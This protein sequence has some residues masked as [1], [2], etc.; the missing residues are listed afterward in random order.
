MIAAMINDKELDPAVTELLVR[1]RKLNIF[2]VFIIKPYFK[3]QK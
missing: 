2:V 1:G 3:V